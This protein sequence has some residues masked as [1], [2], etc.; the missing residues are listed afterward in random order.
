M[1]TVPPHSTAPVLSCSAPYSCCTQLPHITLLLYTAPQLDEF[2][3]LDLSIISLL[4]APSVSV[5]LL[6][7]RVR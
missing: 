7:A 5:N 4:N 2:V 6:P 1:F 3:K